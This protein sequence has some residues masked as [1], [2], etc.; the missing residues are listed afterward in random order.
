MTSLLEGAKK[1]VTRGTD[2]GA[3]VAGLDAAIINPAIAKLAFTDAARELLLG[4][5]PQAERWID[6]QRA[7]WQ[8]RSDRMAAFAETLHQE[9]L[10]RARSHRRQR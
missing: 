6:E 10:S 5:D 3:R 7:L 4:R 8:A 1:L 2:I 9:E